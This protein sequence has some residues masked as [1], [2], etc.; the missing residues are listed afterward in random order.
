[1]ENFSVDQF[2]ELANKTGDL[3]ISIYTPTSR[4]STDSY[5]VDRTHFKNKLQE[6]EA[7]LESRH[8]MRE[9]DAKN[10][11]KPAYSLLEDYDFWKYNL[12]MLAYF[13][14]DGEATLYQLPEKIAQGAHVIGKRPFL[15]PLIPQL[16]NDGQFYLL[17]LDLNRIRLYEGSRNSIRELD[18]D[19]EEVAV[20]FAEEEEQSENIH[21]LRGQSTDRAVG[22]GFVYDGHGEGS[23]EHKKATVLNYFHRMSDMLTPKLNERPLPLFLAGIDYLIPMFHEA[24]KYHK[25]QKGHISGTLDGIDLR[26]LNQKAWNLAKEHFSVEMENRKKDF[27]FKAS[28]NLAIWSDHEKLIKAAI[29]GGVDTLLVNTDHRHLWGTF[30]SDNFTLNFDE[31]STGENH[32]LIDL[33]AAKVIEN[34]GAVYM[35]APEKMPEETLIAG[36]L[37][38][39]V[40]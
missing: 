36:T 34:G 8:K 31:G 15:L 13:I 40:Q 23:D 39:E 4:Q 24:N 17:Y 16:T 18:L 12:D 11:L 20:S 37:R 22:G 1:M 5:H 10:L 21:N 7:E 38:Y 29:T 30:D 27:G 28:R 25:L 9:E 32:C 14:I 26:D 2:K 3:V 6:I 19:P 35:T 33:A